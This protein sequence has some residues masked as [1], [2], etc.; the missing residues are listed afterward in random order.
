MSA[1]GLDVFDTT[2][3]E[4]N[5]W[6]KRVM[7]ELRTADRRVAFGVLRATLHALR[8]RIGPQ[9][10]I[11]FAAQLPML[12]RGAFYEGWHLSE[13]PPHTRHLDEFLQEIEAQIPPQWRID[14]A[15]AA[16]ASFAAIGASIDAGEVLKLIRLLPSE[17]R[18]L[19]QLPADPIS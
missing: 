11:H 10:A 6:L 13:L 15:E 14:A 7:D 8:D 19:V 3:Q 16:A 17:L 12:L 1:T 2:L 18:C 5:V 4:T 9:N